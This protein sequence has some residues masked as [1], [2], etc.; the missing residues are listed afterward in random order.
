VRP[1]DHVHV[2]SFG[3]GI[4]REVRNGGRYLVEIKGR[5]I[6]VRQA[7]LAPLDERK[8]RPTGAGQP[9]SGVPEILTQ[10]HAPSTLDL[11][12]KTREEA[13]S[14]LD[15]F[16]SDAILGGLA[17]VRIIHGRS[18]GLVKAAVHA[19]LKQ[20]TSIAGCRIDPRNAGVTIVA[21]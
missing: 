10:A 13:V 8:P 15:G 20:M 2:A 19:R 21:L 18:G 6:L 17:E 16:L 11:H 4:V 12:G 14:A 1:G 3:K 7:Q 5:A 9:P